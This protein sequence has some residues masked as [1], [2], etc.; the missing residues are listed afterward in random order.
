MTFPTNQLVELCK[1]FSPN[2]TNEQLEQFDLYAKML[3]EWNE[4][5]NLTAITDPEQIVIKH[6]YDCALILKNFGL[7]QGASVIDVGTGA[8]FPGVVLKIL[9]PD[10]KLTLLDSLNKRINFLNE[11]CAA[12]KIDVTTIHAR[13]ED[14][15]QKNGLRE[16]F[17]VA[18]ARAV[19]RLNVLCEYCLPFVKKGGTFLSLKGPAANEEAVEAKNAIKVLGGELRSICSE[20][21]ADNEQRCFV[22]IKKISQTPPKYPRISAK[23]KKQ[24]L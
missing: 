11:L 16:Q 12:L 1:D 7:K 24:P 23:L 14:A 20:T 4:K 18:T 8:G 9:R 5:I 13:A 17:D 3:V 19:A 6:F 21:I 22:I 2:I 10:I 15:A